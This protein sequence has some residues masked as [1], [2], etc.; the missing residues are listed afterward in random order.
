ML[1]NVCS[2]SPQP[3]LPPQTHVIVMHFSQTS[4]DVLV[5]FR[6]FNCHYAP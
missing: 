6:C 1:L 2:P 5:V 4:A 3:P